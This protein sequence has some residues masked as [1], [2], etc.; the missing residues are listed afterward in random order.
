MLRDCLPLPPPNS[1]LY[2]ALTENWKCVDVR[3]KHWIEW[4]K[5]GSASP[6]A[7]VYWR[8]GS[9]AQ[10]PRYDCGARDF[11]RETVPW[12]YLLGNMQSGPSGLTG[13]SNPNAAELIHFTSWHM[14][15]NSW[16]LSS[17]QSS[18]L[19]SS[20]QTSGSQTGG[21]NFQGRRYAI[22]TNKFVCQ[23]QPKYS[24]SCLN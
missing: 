8:V 1:P 14:V 10:S 2:S 9:M 11:A 20:V 15:I 3:W 24:H 17:S 19:F 16:W 23:I 7:G 6:T 4:E 5:V 21:R 12:K 13:A 18:P 22:A